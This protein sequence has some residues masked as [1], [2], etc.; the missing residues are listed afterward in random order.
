MRNASQPNLVLYVYITSKL[1]L[2]Q[3]CKSGF[4]TEETL[5]ISFIMLV[6][7]DFGALCRITSVLLWYQQSL[8]GI[9]SCKL[10]LPLPCGVP[11]LVCTMFLFA[12]CLRVFFNALRAVN[13]PAK[14]FPRVGEKFPNTQ[15]SPSEGQE[16][17]GVSS[18]L[19]L[20]LGQF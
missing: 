3:V 9:T 17:V 1:S 11:R 19:F 13:Q 20:L 7:E 2:S 5:Q 16:L 8:T 4:T 18:C 14:C 6:M 10:R 15:P 12:S